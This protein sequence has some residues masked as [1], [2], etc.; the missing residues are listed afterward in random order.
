MT[1]EA[2]EAARL[3][4]MSSDQ[5]IELIGKAQEAYATAQEREAQ[6]RDS[7]QHQLTS[8]A[9]DL[10]ARLGPEHPASGSLGSLREAAMLSPDELA[11]Q[12]GDALHLLVAALTDV[13]CLAQRVVL[14]GASQARG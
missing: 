4:D 5:L 13:T 2:V 10:G 6:A 1:A 3:G 9:A 12:H 7:A 8:A 11:A 14:I